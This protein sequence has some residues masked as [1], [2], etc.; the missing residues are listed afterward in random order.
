MTSDKFIAIILDKRGYH[1]V[2]V[3]ADLGESEIHQ[4][5]SY[6]VEQTGTYNADVQEQNARLKASRIAKVTK[7]HM[8]QDTIVWTTAVVSDT[9]VH[10]GDDIRAVRTAI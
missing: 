10:D 2:L 6:L 3:K 1:V 8:F 7:L 9:M 4:L 5:K